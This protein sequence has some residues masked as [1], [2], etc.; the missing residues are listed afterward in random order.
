MHESFHDAPEEYQ[1]SHLRVVCGSITPTAEVRMT[2][3]W[4]GE[5]SA[6]GTGDGPIAA[7]FTAIS[8]ILGRQIEV[9]SLSL[10]SLTPGRDSVGQVFL[11]AKVDGKTLSGNGAS[12]DIVEASAR[13][14]VH[15]LN[16]A[17][18][19]DRLEA[20]SLNA[21]YLWGV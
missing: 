16:K 2:G 20:S 10:R 12:T 18:H 9:M 11:Q 17:H 14:L 13:A 8:E 5:R 4:A 15:A 21:I 1:L 3:P 6:R 7:A 19:A